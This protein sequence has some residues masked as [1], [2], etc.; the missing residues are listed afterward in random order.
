MQMAHS[1]HAGVAGGCLA[2]SCESAA[3]DLPAPATGRGAGRGWQARGDGP[4][5]QAGPVALRSISVTGWRSLRWCHDGEQEVDQPVSIQAPGREVT[6]TQRLLAAAVSRGQHLA[7][8]D[9]LAGPAC[10]AELADTV[11]SAAAGLAWRGLQPGDAV[12]VY[13]PDAACYVL[14]AHAVRAAGGVPSPV[15]SGLTVAEAAGQLADCGA[16]LLLTGPP[17]DRV[18]QAAAERSQVRQV[19][20]FGEAPGAVQFSAV[21]QM[22]TLPARGA[23]PRDHALL[24]YM[25]KPDGV[26]CPAPV[27]HQDLTDMLSSLEAEAGICETDVVLAVPPAGDGVSYTALLDHALLRG[28]TVVPAAADALGAAA[29]VHH[30][31]AVIAAGEAPAAVRGLRVLTVAS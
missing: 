4:G 26:L 2:W 29:G 24:P 3:R 28:A 1:A 20:S 9:G 10:Y 30:A 25:R 13:V 17:L 8:A 16:R 14:A 11:R 18:A 6:V 23:R 5:Q 27:T 19:I 31:T 7:L 15:A 12:G 21:L 22:G